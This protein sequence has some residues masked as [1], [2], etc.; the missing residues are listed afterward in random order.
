LHATLQEDA[1]N[2]FERFLGSGFIE[3]PLRSTLVAAT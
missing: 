1:L 3:V 2:K